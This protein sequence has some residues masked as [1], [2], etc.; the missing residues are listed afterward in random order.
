MALPIAG[1]K[2][3]FRRFE[4]LDNKISILT[5]SLMVADTKYADAINDLTTQLS[6]KNFLWCIYRM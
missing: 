3:D 2:T 4:E 1:V 6:E 5:Q